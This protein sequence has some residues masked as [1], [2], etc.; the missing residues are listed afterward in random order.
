MS[1]IDIIEV[2]LISAELNISESEVFFL[3]RRLG[4]L[5][6]YRINTVEY[7]ARETVDMMKS[8]LAEQK[9]DRIEND[10]AIRRNPPTY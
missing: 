7:F 1:T 8:R 2:S 10:N 9:K 5:P 3:A 4:Y 6:Y